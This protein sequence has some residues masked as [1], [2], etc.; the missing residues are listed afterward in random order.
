MKMLNAWTLEADDPALAV[1]EILEQLD[2][3]NRLLA[4]A[5]GFITCSYDYVETGMVKAVCEALP[6]EVVGCTTLTN[7]IDRQAGT[8]LLCLSVLTSDDCRFAT[9]LTSPLGDNAHAVISE[10]YNQAAAKLGERPGLVLAFFPMLGAVSG[11]FMLRALNDAAAGA[12]IFGTTACDPATTDYSNSF[13]IHNGICS[14]EGMS[15][16]LISGGVHPHFVVASASEQNMFRQQA[17]ITSSE[18]SVLKKINGLSVQQYL[19]SIGLAQGEGIGGLSSMLFVVNY[20]DGS[21]PVARAVYALNKDGTAGCGG[22]MPEGGTLSIGR[23]D[24][25]DILLT[26]EQALEKLQ[27]TTGLNGIIIFPC[28]VRNMM[29]GVEPLREIEKVQSVVANSLPWHL[30]YSGGEICPVYGGDGG[31]LNRFHNY[32]FIACAI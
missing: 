18:G 10:T 32:T 12:P 28:L 24:V 20:N 27:K 9:A 16:L 31:T 22:V 21:Q 14:R 29:L 2:L 19:A 26:A 25:D 15:L 30:A 8:L 23:L 5:A 6:F 11:E 3:K 17:V 1:S 13:T 4:Q 7:A